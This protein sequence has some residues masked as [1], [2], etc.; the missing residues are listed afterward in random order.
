MLS[1]YH[2]N[3]DRSRWSQS[4]PVAGHLFEEPGKLEVVANLAAD[5][6]LRHFLPREESRIAGEF[7]KKPFHRDSFQ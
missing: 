2:S 4:V 5:W 3:R 6:F 7:A 1:T